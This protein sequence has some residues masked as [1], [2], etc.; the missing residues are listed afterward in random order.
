MLRIRHSKTQYIFQHLPAGSPQE[1]R[2]R[3][4]WR[5]RRLHRKIPH[6]WP[7]RRH[8]RHRRHLPAVKDTV[9]QWK[10]RNWLVVSTYPSEKYYIVSWEVGMIIQF[11]INGKSKKS[12]VPKHQPAIGWGVRIAKWGN[13][14]SSTHGIQNSCLATRIGGDQWRL[15]HQQD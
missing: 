15:T 9:T 13:F 12:M 3:Q 1:V 7:Q 11:H 6:C 2:F 5:T 8:R 10:T 14:G 4:P